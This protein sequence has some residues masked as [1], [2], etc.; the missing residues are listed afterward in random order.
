MILLVRFDPATVKF[1]TEDTEPAQV[2]K[3]F[4]IPEVTITGALAAITFNEPL[5]SSE[6]PVVELMTVNLKLY[7]PAADRGIT[8]VIV[9]FVGSAWLE[10]AVKPGMALEDPAT[11]EYLSSPTE[12]LEKVMLKLVASVVTS[13]IVPID[14]VGFATVTTK[15]AL[16]IGL[17]SQ[18][19]AFT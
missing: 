5:Y 15:V 3:A 4:K 11:I 17:L 10:T 7:V 9:P 6:H 19:E 2:E 13:E 1:W 16:D 14:T 8:T 18:P 12:A